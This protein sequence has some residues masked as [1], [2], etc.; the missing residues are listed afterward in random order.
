[1][2]NFKVFVHF[3][4]EKIEESIDS[5]EDYAQYF[6]RIMFLLDRADCE[7]GVKLYYQGSNKDAFVEHLSDISYVYGYNILS[8][9]TATNILLQYANDWEDSPSKNIDDS[10]NVYRIWDFDNETLISEFSNTLKEVLEH[11]DLNNDKVLLINIENSISANHSFVVVLKYCRN[12]AE[13]PKLAHIHF[14]KDFTNLDLW[15]KNNRTPRLINTTDERH[16][17]NSVR[18]I[19]GKSPILYDLRRDTEAVEHLLNL[20]NNAVTDQRVSKDLMNYDS[21]QDRYIWFE[22]ENAQNQYHAYHLAKPRTHEADE[23]AV[24]KIPPRVKR[25]IDNKRQ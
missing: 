20:L 25:F 16:N 2:D 9:D 15:F 14:V 23:E 3:P 13:L 5:E 24:S 6:E 22:N 11:I 12:L 18:Y 7:K 8:P 10:N 17:E 1:M 19:K 21:K 4:T